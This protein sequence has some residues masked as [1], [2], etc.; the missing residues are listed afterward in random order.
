VPPNGR[1]SLLELDTIVFWVLAAS[2]MIDIE[3]ILSESVR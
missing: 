2:F 3:L 1:K